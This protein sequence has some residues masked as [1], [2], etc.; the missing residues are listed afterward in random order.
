MFESLQSM[1]FARPNFSEGGLAILN[2]AIAI[3]MFGVALGM[4]IDQF[5]NLLK[6]PKPILIGF[7]S[8]YFLLPLVS[9]ILVMLLWNNITVGVGMGMI[10]VAAAPG[11]NVSNFLSSYSRSN[12]A[13]SISLTAISTV[14]AIFLMPFNF[15][16]YGKLYS[17]IGPWGDTELLRKLD[18]DVFE[19]FKTIFIILGVPV[20]LG[21]L[22][23]HF[24]PT[25]TKYAKK[26]LQIFS[27]LF[28]AAMVVILFYNNYTYFIDYIS[29]IF[30]LVLLHN[31]LALS[32]GYY[33]ARLFKLAKIDCRT[34]SIETGIQNSGL[35]LI[36]LFNPS[37][38]PSHLALGGMMIITAWWGV[39]HIISGFT[40]ASI[41]RRKTII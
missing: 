29:A 12:I 7:L 35:A 38:F 28:F 20:V 19:M 6:K 30:I 37:I 13:L 22:T 4:D 41:W 10:L 2:I 3:I 27:I 8:Q 1:E 34:I 11:G 17:L 25:F 40:I 9:F 26:Y 18:I 24:F 36:L 15:Y 39:W 31:L 14:V 16:I 21:M 32:S 5:K 23:N 33:F